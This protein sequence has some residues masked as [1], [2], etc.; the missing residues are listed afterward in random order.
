ML[1][2]DS[3]PRAP[4]AAGWVRIEGSG[5]IKE[6]GCRLPRSG[7]SE[8]ARGSNIEAIGGV[9]GEYVGARKKMR[10]QEASTDAGAWRGGGHV[11]FERKWCRT[12]A[13]HKIVGQ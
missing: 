6:R 11:C 1:R 7:R 10:I 3:R 2:W 4:G 9:S 12:R 5:G 13:V 8:E